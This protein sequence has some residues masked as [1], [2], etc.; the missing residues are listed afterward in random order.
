MPNPT[1]SESIF[2]PDASP[3]TKKVRTFTK[4]FHDVDAAEDL[5]QSAKRVLCRIISY[6]SIRPSQ[7]MLAKDL[8]LCL[9]TV[10]RSV[11]LLIACGYLTA[12]RRLGKHRRNVYHAIEKNVTTKRDEMSHPVVDRH[13]AREIDIP[14]VVN[15]HTYAGD[16]ASD[17]GTRNG[18]DGVVE[19]LPTED[20]WTEGERVVL[21]AGVYS[22]DVKHLAAGRTPADLRSL[23]A[24]AIAADP[25]NVAAYY[26]ALL[27]RCVIPSPAD[28]PQS[29]A[30]RYVHLDREIPAAPKQS[31]PTAL[32]TA[33]G[34]QSEQP[35]SNPVVH[36][37]LGT[38]RWLQR[39]RDV[40][41]QPEARVAPFP[42]RVI[43]PPARMQVDLGPDEIFRRAF[44]G[45]RLQYRM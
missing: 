38:P 4:A 18:Y 11:D 43:P 2:L 16:L 24:T 17:E 31:E 21:A 19:P 20:S 27:Q 29:K 6:G 23:H 1:T 26:V 25:R 34:V 5:T 10:I 45:K 28:I 12:D 40:A 41:R 44:G 13:L 14:V 33:T 42:E 22:R 35:R 39:E 36:N 3:T 15:T 30:D 7:S 9:R 37:D 32:D 8:R